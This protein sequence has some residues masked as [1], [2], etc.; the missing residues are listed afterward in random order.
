MEFNNQ[1]TPKENETYVERIKRES[2]GFHKLDPEFVEREKREQ[3]GY[4]LKTIKDLGRPLS[5]NELRELGNI[6]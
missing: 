5:E 1:L 2:T 4:L 6:L 3:V